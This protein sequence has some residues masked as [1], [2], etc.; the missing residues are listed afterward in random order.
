MTLLRQNDDAMSFLRYD[1]VII[2][3]CVRWDFILRLLD[4][5]GDGSAVLF[6]KETLSRKKQLQTWVPVS[7][8]CF[9]FFE[10]TNSET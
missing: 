4:I 6:G 8:V 2:T 9:N 1:D 7:C 5:Y 10:L 3:S